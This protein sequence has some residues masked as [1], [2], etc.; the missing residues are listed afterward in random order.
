[1]RPGVLPGTNAVEPRKLVRVRRS[2]WASPWEM[3]VLLARYLRQTHVDAVP[4][5]ARSPRH[6]PAD[7]L[8]PWSYGDGAVVRV[9]EG[10]REL[11][12]DPS[13]LQCAVGEVDPDLWG[14]S[15]L[16]ESRTLLPAA[17]PSSQER[18]YT[19]RPSTL[20]S[21]SPPKCAASHDG[22]SLSR[23]SASARRRRTADAPVN[24]ARSEPT[25]SGP[26]VYR[27]SCDE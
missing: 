22:R 27:R 25:P 1:V 7:P 3:A 17:P 4:M 6:G 23:T 24:V 18:R 19:F 21:V 11:W 16:D 20:V 2:G 26:N 9:R 14:A 15:L 8:N 10:E 13:C 12:I 5:M